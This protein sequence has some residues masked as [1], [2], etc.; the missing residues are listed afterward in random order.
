MVSEVL[1]ILTFPRFALVLSMQ[2]LFGFAWLTSCCLALG[3]SYLRFQ[4]NST[5]IALASPVIMFVYLW[6]SE[7]IGNFAQTIYCS[8]LMRMYLKEEDRPLRRSFLT[9][10]TLVGSACL[11]ATVG[12]PGSLQSILRQAWV[13]RQGT[14]GTAVEDTGQLP[15]AVPCP[16]PVLEYCGAWANA[17]ASMRDVSHVEAARLAKCFLTCANAEVLLEDLLMKSI[18]CFGSLLCGMLC[19][20][21][22]VAASILRQSEKGPMYCSGFIGLLF[23]FVCGRAAMGFIV[24]SME[25]FILLW[26]EEPEPFKELEIHQEFELRIAAEL[27]REFGTLISNGTPVPEA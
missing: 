19:S 16:G 1:K 26:S 10:C 13:R 4:E 11:G 20:V 18:R 8:L 3:A 9:A 24:H 6:G 15:S 17:V 21:T 22:C 14:S 23:G 12:P 27:S 5:H 25:A 2:L 7:V